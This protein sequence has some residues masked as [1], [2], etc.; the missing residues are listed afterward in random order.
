[1]NHVHGTLAAIAVTL[2]AIMSGCSSDAGTGEKQDSD[3][4]TASRGEHDRDGGEHGGEGNGEH[5]RDG[6]GH[7]GGEGEESGA[8]LALDES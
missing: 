8:E 2:A 6:D 7:Q 3:G 1:M 5:D 4:L